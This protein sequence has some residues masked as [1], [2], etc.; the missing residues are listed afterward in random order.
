MKLNKYKVGIGELN[1]TVMAP[2]ATT[3]AAF[4]GMHVDE[5]LVF[6]TAVYEKNDQ[7]YEGHR[8]WLN[9]QLGTEKPTRGEMKKIKRLL[10]HCKFIKG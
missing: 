5:K 7:P 6:A 9:W 2:N 4:F 10:E 3:A 1:A 8:K